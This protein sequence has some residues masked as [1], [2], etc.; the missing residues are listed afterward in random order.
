MQR[1]RAAAAAAQ[2][3]VVLPAH[4]GLSQYERERLGRIARN[5]AFMQSLGLGGGL[6]GAAPAQRRRARGRARRARRRGPRGG[7][8]A[9]RARRRPATPL[10]AP[11]TATKPRAAAPPPPTEPSAVA[12]YL[13]P[14]GAVDVSGE[15]A[16]T[17]ADDKLKRVYAV[18]AA[19]RLVAAAGQGGRVAVFCGRAGAAPLASF[20]A[21]GGWVGGCGFIGADKLLTGGQRRSRAPLGLRFFSKR[22]LT[23]VAE[24]QHARGIWRLACR[25]ATAATCAKDGCVV[26]WSASATLL[27][28]VKKVGGERRGLRAVRGA[29]GSGGCGGGGRRPR[30]GLGPAERRAG[31]VN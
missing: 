1:A 29:H 6:A 15:D 2:A 9:S 16:T 14:A 4:D 8:R 12:P 3:T 24:A 11:T 22:T 31:V 10:A 26:V 17:F 25:G 28:K 19:G 5:E 21:H 18:A 13:A 20:K 23:K 30:D 27:T 7:R